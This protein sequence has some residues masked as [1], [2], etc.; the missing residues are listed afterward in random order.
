MKPNWLYLELSVML[1][2]F[3]YFSSFGEFVLMYF[4]M[5]TKCQRILVEVPVMIM[6]I[7]TMFEYHQTS[8][9]IS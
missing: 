4:V 6:F 9:G 1:S 2:V 3:M 8:N 7:L 5:E